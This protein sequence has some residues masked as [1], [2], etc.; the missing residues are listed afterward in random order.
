MADHSRKSA[1]SRRFR[2]T[3]RG[4]SPGLIDSTWPL[5]VLA[6]ILSVLWAWE[7]PR[8]A[9]GIDFYH[10]WVVGQAL[11]SSEV[12][13]IYSDEDRTRIGVEFLER[14][15]AD[16]SALRQR[17]AAEYRKVLATTASPFLYTS[18]YLFLSGNY[19]TDF[20]RYQLFGLMCTVVSL[21]SLCHLLNYSLSQSL[22]ALLIITCWFEPLFSDM[23]V[24]NVNQLQV[25]MLTLFLWNQTR[26]S[27][28][29]RD[30]LGGL[31]LGFAVLFKPNVAIAP[32]VLV[33]SWLINRE[34]RKLR[35][36][37]LG[38]AI[39]GAVGFAVSSIFFGSVRC[40]A[41]W[42]LAAS[43]ISGGGIA[44]DEGNVALARVIVESFGVATDAYLVTGLLGITA[45]LL[46][47]AR[48]ETA[49]AHGG[50]AG[51]LAEPEGGVDRDALAAAMGLL[52]Y[53]LG[54]RLVWIHYYLLAI[55]AILIA[56]RPLRVEKATLLRRLLG[57]ASLVPL[58]RSRTMIV[59]LEEHPHAYALLFSA[60][61]LVLYG[62]V[63]WELGLRGQ[64]QGLAGGARRVGRR[65][66]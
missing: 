43:T 32:A 27:P 30:L 36:Q 52:V 8:S 1:P 26:R 66:G 6:A 47:R 60:S 22:I 24:G 56:L 38:M 10:F 28:R 54:T 3:G 51:R 40:W 35:D 23:R 5:L 55:P 44:I 20:R 41:D 29:S 14:A 62:I 33:L 11:S 37:C 65:T 59:G 50:T 58:I 64:L 7:Y 34:F 46:W 16:K 31:I 15:K 25:A 13:N 48:S 63:I 21:L 19:E 61:A 17:V 53:L 9:A 4:L 12:T 18:F 42:I 45:V 2:E 39:A 57:V 49:S